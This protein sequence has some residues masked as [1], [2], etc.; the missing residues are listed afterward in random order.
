MRKNGG[1]RPSIVWRS[2]FWR[3]IYGRR[4]RYSRRSSYGRRLSYDY[5]RSRQQRKGRDPGKVALHRK[6]KQLIR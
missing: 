6:G 3:P 2:K 4:P 1:V 5:P